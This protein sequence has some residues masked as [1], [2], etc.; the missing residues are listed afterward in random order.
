MKILF[1]GATGF[2]GRR[3]IQR[4]SAHD[5]FGLARS[6]ASAQA[7]EGMDVQPILADLAKPDTLKTAL[8]D[9]EFDAAMHLAAEIATQRNAKKVWAVNYEGTEAL[10]EALAAQESLKSF[11]FASTVV[12][13]EADGQLLT[14][15]TDFNIETQYGRSKHESEKQMLARFAADGFPAMIIRPSHIYGPGGW[16]QQLMVDLKRGLFM[17]P[18]SGENFWD[19]VHVDDVARAFVTVL[20]K[21]EAGE[22]YHVVDDTP[23][24]MKAFFAEAAPYI[25]KKKV[26][27]AP[28]WLANL[29]KGKD[30]IIAGKRSAKSS[31]AKLK[32]LGWA[33]EFADYKVGLADVFA[34]GPG[35]LSR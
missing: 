22:I 18:G 16:F 17:I 33:P 26:G 4:L 20:E 2:L 28:I 29:L 12:V 32:G 6:P 31:N 3:I 15:E 21:G 19:V 25:G 11:I 24:T 8:A 14:E 34:D 27:H 35:W 10:L 13:G 30:A 7:L 5:L 23:V 1:T 9:Y